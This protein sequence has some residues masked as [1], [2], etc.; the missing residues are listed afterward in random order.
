MSQW[1]LWFYLILGL[2]VCG[3]IAYLRRN[4][5]IHIPLI[6][7][8][9]FIVAMFILYPVGMRYGTDLD[10]FC[11]LNG[12]VQS[13]TYEEPWTEE[14]WESESYASGRDSKGNTTYST[15]RVRK[16]RYHGPEWHAN[17]TVGSWG[18]HS[19]MYAGYVNRFSNQRQT[20][21]SHSGQCSWGDGKTFTTSWKGDLATIIPVSNTESVIN[22]VKASKGT[23][24]RGKGSDVYKVLPYPTLMDTPRGPKQPRVLSAGVP[25]KS[26]WIQA[27]EWDMDVLAD[28]V[29]SN[30]QANPLLYFTS[31]DPGYA[32]AIKSEWIGGKKNDVIIVIG[33][34]EWPKVEWI[35]VIAWSK[36]AGFTAESRDA[37]TMV[38]LNNRE[39]LTRTVGQLIRT[40]FER[41]PMSS[42]EYLK[43]DVETPRWIHFV[44]GLLILVAGL[45]AGL[46]PDQRRRW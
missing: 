24:L 6:T 41:N 7:A 46:I 40:K 23:V 22:W 17:T 3:V 33:V 36:N 8:G 31:A 43:A 4:D 1:T 30:K 2:I 18:I 42:F 5:G 44:A 11:V 37:L 26:E 20:G 21:S 45:C 9:S 14:Y 32:E 27:T 10:D 16:T 28:A 13:A 29:G 38:D 15:R 12:H 25:L 19:S 35:E 34:K 39:Q